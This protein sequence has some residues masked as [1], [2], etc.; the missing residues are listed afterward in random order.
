MAKPRFSATTFNLYNLNRPGLPIYTDRDGWTQVEYDRKIDY[1]ARMLRLLS[2]DVYGFQE[3]WHAGALDD[4]L[5]AAGMAEEYVALVPQGHAGGKIVCGGAVRREMLDGEPRWIETFPEAFVMRSGGDDPQ[6]SD[7]SVSLNS[8]SR[9]VL[10]FRVKP[11]A[12]G[13]SVH[14]FVC[15]FKSK[16]PTRI[17]GEGWYEKDVH[18]KHQEAIGAGLSTVRRTAEA[19]ALRMILTDLMKGTN[20]P[21]MVLGDVND[22]LLSNTLNILTGQPRYLMGFSTGGGDTDLYTAQTLQQYRSTR[23]VYYTHVFQ[24]ERESLDQILVSQEFYDNSK[25]R[26]W[27]FK[28]LVVH[29][30]H[31]NVEDH[32][33]DG[34]N[35][36]G[37]IR[38]TF[39]HDPLKTTPT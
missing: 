15:H 35:D 10:N 24:N 3:L 27:S 38:A 6:T 7:I 30:D 20:E 8:F 12:D 16:G 22:G 21:V 2:S 37:I 28:E 11:V 29:N 25:R 31:L 5:A 39:E 34:S 1:T 33:A 26:I 32:K 9:P 36:H 14:V 13:P 18:S 17:N 19:T 4:A 23:D